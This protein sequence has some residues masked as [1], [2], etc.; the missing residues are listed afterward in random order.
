MLYKI[1][2]SIKDLGKFD[3]K[4]T[5]LPKYVLAEDFY[6]AIKTA[7]KFETDNLTLMDCALYLGDGSVAVARGFKGFEAPSKDTGGEVTVE[8]S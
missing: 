3:A 8:S 1:D 5:R 6:A 4:T 2:Y 7:K